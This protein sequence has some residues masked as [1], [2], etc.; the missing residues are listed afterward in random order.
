MGSRTKNERKRRMQDLFS[1]GE[2]FRPDPESPDDDDL[3]WIKKLNNFEQDEARRI[4]QSQRALFVRTMNREGS[5]ELWVL[6][7]GVAK[8]TDERLIEA[9]LASSYAKLMGKASNAVH[10]DPDWH[11]RID[12]MENVRR[13]TVQDAERRT[14]DEVT[15]EYLTEIEKRRQAIEASDRHDLQSLDSDELR[16]RYVEVFI[17]ARATGV[18]MREMRYAEVLFGVRMCDAVMGEGGEYEHKT[19]THLPLYDDH[20]E[21]RTLDDILMAQYGRAFDRL[22]V[23]PHQAKGSARRQASSGP[24]RQQSEEE[25]SSPSTQ[26][27]TSPEPVG[28]SA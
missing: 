10:A 28:T 7:D 23:A 21:V 6:K 19:C 27:V 2:I 26:E 12:M 5:D 24:S 25:D 20:D 22:N 1:E 16:E 14:L 13:D 8:M 17:E 9:I 11:E 4:A 15:A 18:F 3:L